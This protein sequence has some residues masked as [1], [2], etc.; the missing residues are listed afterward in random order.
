VDVILACAFIENAKTLGKHIM[1][2]CI[3][4]AKN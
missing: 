2:I 3:L 1:H 4:M